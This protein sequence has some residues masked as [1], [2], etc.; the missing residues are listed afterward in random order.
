MKLQTYMVHVA[1]CVCLPAVVPGIHTGSRLEETEVCKCPLVT[2]AGASCTNAEEN[3][4][5]G[6]ATGGHCLPMPSTPTQNKNT[7]GPPIANICLRLCVAN[8]P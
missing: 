5:H 7:K 1:S 8:C 2:S 3:H 6:Q 4:Q